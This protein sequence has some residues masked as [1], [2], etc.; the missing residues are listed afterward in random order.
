MREP[1]LRAAMEDYLD[2]IR[3]FFPAE[4]LEVRDGERLAASVPSR[5]R[6]VTLDPA[7]REMGSEAF[8][9][10]VGRAMSDGVSGIAFLV[11]GPDGLP[12]GLSKRAD[13]RLS[14]SKLTLPHRL[15]RIVLAEQ[16]YRAIT[17]LRG[18]PYPR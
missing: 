6:T 4:E 12:E 2:R 14:L 5:F 1:H 7:G 9:A 11:G 15:A 17:I 16:I 3:R 13:L 10:F 8:A 18:L